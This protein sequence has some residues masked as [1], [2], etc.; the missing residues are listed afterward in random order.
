MRRAISEKRK[1]YA[2]DKYGDVNMSKLINNFM[3]SGKRSIAEKFVYKGLEEVAKAHSSDPVSVLNKVIENVSPN[4]K[5]ISRRFGSATY[6]VPKDIKPEEKA[7]KAIKMIVA[8]T[9]EL[10]AKPS[11]KKNEK[12]SKKGTSIL[13]AFIKTF[14][15]AFNN[16]GPA[17]QKKEELHK[18]AKENEAFSHL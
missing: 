17:V 13:I 14:E 9:R 1:I 11:K 15:M 10:A 4:K 6:S 2:D 16:E 5:I 18:I 8:A 12:V 3:K 7:T